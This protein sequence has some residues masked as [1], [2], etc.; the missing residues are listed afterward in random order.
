[1]STVVSE[2]EESFRIAQELKDRAEARAHQAL[3]ELEAAHA[4]I[5]Y[6]DTKLDNTQLTLAEESAQHT[7]TKLDRSYWKKKYDELSEEM[8]F[9][10]LM[11]KEIIP[12][13]A[14]R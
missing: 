3:L 5:L 6:L 8:Y 9:I 11:L 10:H 12:V 13:T 14:P 2:L 1:M 4:K 7:L